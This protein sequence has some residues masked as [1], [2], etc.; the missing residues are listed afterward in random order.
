MKHFLLTT[1]MYILLMVS[2]FV[3]PMSK[4]LIVDVVF[5]TLLFVPLVGVSLISDGL[6]RITNNRIFDISLLLSLSV[7]I[8]VLFVSLRKFS[9]WGQALK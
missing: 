8:T 1:V 5:L 6:F 2:I 3:K 7:L 4:H 9:K